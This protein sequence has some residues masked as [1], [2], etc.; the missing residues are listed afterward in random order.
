M[1]RI[2]IDPWTSK[3]VMRKATDN[4]DDILNELT[5]EYGDDFLTDM[6]PMELAKLFFVNGYINGG[7]DASKDDDIRE[8]FITLN[9]EIEYQREHPIL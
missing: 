4:F 3:S 7:T 9:G 6:E 8:D 5:N 1:N 2:E